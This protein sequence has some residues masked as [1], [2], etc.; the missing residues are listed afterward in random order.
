MHY[1]SRLCF[2]IVSFFF[3]AGCGHKELLKK[4]LV[5]Y[6]KVNDQVQLMMKPLTA[7]ESKQELGRNAL[8]KGYQPIK[9]TVENNSD[10]YLVLHPWYIGLPITSPKKVARALHRNN[11]LITMGS[12]GIGAIGLEW[13]SPLSVFFFGALPLSLLV[14]WNNEKISASVLNDSIGRGVE[15]IMIP[16]HA[17]IKRSI[18]VYEADF[19]SEFMFTLFNTRDNKAIKFEVSLEKPKE[20]P[21]LPIITSDPLAEAPHI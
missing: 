19:K 14:D 3:F 21:H 1:Y 7:Q 12:L 11:F 18:Y 17:H 8:K 2:V 10:A 6:S 5:P 20:V 15:T 4:Q 9:F 16:P 13:F